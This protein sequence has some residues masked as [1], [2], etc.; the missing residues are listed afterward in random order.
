M[1]RVASLLVLLVLLFAVSPA[2]KHKSK[3][4]NPYDTRI[5]FRFGKKFYSMHLC[6][7]GMAYMVKGKGTNYTEP[8]AI[9]SSDTS[10]VFKID[11]LQATY[12][13]LDKLKA[14]PRIDTAGTTDAPRIEIYYDDKKIYDSFEWSG[15]IWDLFRPMIDKLPQGY[16]PFSGGEHPFD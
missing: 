12:K 14:K 5:D 8:F 11:S 1:K 10:K 2:C 3:S 9:M 7:Q 13:L 6:K 16:N 15:G 4:T